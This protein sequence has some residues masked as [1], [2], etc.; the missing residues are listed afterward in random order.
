MDGGR[1]GRTRLGKQWVSE[2]EGD[3]GFYVA[4]S[5]GRADLLVFWGLHCAEDVTLRWHPV[6]LAQIQVK[7]AVFRHVELFALAS[8]ADWNCDCLS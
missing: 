5:G 2:G 7:Y 3:E 6:T 1:R 4:R 8:K